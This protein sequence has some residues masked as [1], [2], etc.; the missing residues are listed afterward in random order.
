MDLLKIFQRG[1]HEDSPQTEVNPAGDDGDGLEAELHMA[2]AEQLAR[3]GISEDGITIEIRCLGRGIDGRNVYVAMLRLVKWEP[4]SAVRLLLGLPLLQAK[5]RRVLRGSWIHDVSHFAGL[6]LHPSGQFEESGAM[7]GL[8]NLIL[9]IEDLQL[10]ENEL[11][12]S[13][14]SVPGELPSQHAPLK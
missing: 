14:W 11:S 1:S 8:R 9:R 3:G 12:Q 10:Y 13:V 7:H 2:V 6:W 5:V 4:R